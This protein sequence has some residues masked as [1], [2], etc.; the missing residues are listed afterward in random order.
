MASTPTQVSQTQVGFA[1]EVA[2]YATTLLGQA[3]A[4][5]NPNIDAPVYTG[6]MQGFENAAARY[7]QFTPLQ[8]QAFEGAQQ[9][10]PAY[11]LTGATGLAGL[12]G[13]GG[14]YTWTQSSGSATTT[15]SA[16]LAGVVGLAGLAGVVGVVGLI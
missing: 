12:A 7:A 6:G 5:A 14:S 11:Q 3:Q 15:G 10:Q 13:L 16:G 9:M 8:K 2:P 1:P 4:F